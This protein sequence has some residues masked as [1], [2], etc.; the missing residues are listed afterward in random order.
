MARMHRFQFNNVLPQKK[1]S[2]QGWHRCSRCK[3]FL[4]YFAKRMRAILIY[5]SPLCNKDVSVPLRNP[6]EIAIYLSQIS[7]ILQMK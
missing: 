3:S 6:R 1:R 4:P 7:E 5:L 2:F